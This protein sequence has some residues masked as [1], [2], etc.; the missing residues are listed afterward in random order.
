M[1][2]NRFSSKAPTP[3]STVCGKTGVWAQFQPQQLAP[4]KRLSGGVIRAPRLSLH[5]LWCAE[6]TPED[7]GLFSGEVAATPCF[8]HGVCVGS[9]NPT[10]SFYGAPPARPF[11]QPA[12]LP[13]SVER[14]ASF[15][16]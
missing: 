6:F 2:V 11:S 15:S 16:C 14:G 9:L 8:A 4:P 5:E 10:F 1:I 12:N 7:V 3:T 13:G